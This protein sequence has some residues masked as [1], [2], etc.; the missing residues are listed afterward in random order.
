MGGYYTQVSECPYLLS[1][2]FTCSC[3]FDIIRSV[4]T[5][6]KNVH[7]WHLSNFS[8][9][10]S[11]TLTHFI[12]I[13]L[14]VYIF[15]GFPSWICKHIIILL[16]TINF[17]LCSLIYFFICVHDW[18]VQIIFWRDKP[19]L[20]AGKNTNTLCLCVC[21]WCIKYIHA[22][23]GAIYSTI[24]PALLILWIY[25]FYGIVYCPP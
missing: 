6:R 23:S 20:S 25:F 10:L 11:C 21:V 22:V 15:S 5:M 3:V 24:M 8:I 13:L 16:A 1:I 7:S 18:N 14:I 17:I 4:T 12:F 2:Y 9:L 19:A